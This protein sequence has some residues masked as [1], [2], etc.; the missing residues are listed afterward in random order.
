MP[1]QLTTT[2]AGSVSDGLSGN[3][4]PDIQGL[5]A[6]AVLMVVAFHAGLPVPGGFVGVD[7]F[8][9]ISGFV[10]TVMLKREWSQTGRIRLGQFYMRR[11]RR[12]TPALALMVA[13]TVPLSIL[14]LSPFGPQQNA[15][16]T[17]LGAMAFGAN[18]VIARTTG[19]Y[20]DAP[21]ETNPLLNTWSL[22]VEEQFYF[23]FPV[24]M[25][26][27]WTLARHRGLLR[28]SPVTL[29][30]SVAIV[31]FGL[32]LAASQRLAFRGSSIVL[33][34]YSPITR[35]WEFAVGALLALVLAKH[36][37]DASPPLRIGSS[38]I[39][40]CLVS[41]S[42][43]L[44]GDSTP[45]PGSWT[46]LPVVGTLLLLAG[47]HPESI[48]TRLLS[49]KPLVK[50]GDWSYSI[51]LWHWPFI[52]FAGVIWPGRTEFLLAAA[53]TS[54]LP[55]LASYYWV[56]Q[57]IRMSK[58]RSHTR[59]MGL[60]S[61]V[62]LPPVL[63]SAIALPIS[64]QWLAPGFQ[65]GTIGGVIHEG[66]VGHNEFHRFV[67]TTYYPCTPD[68]IRREALYW[69][70]FLRCQQSL[71]ETEVEVALV[72]DSHAE[73]LFLGLAE[74]APDTNIGYYILGALPVRSSGDGMARILDHVTYSPAIHTVVL[75]AFWAA[76]G[77]PEKEL[78][79]TIKRLQEA[80][81]TVFVTDDVPEFPF[82]PGQCRN[83]IALLIAGARC[84][85][86][87]WVNTE[88]Y[89][90]VITPLQ[91]VIRSV[92]GAHL[93]ETNK[94]FCG[95]NSC[96][97]AYGSRLLYRDPDHLN[98]NGTR[99]LADHLITDNQQLREA[100]DR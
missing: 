31:S 78:T 1:A 27:G 86:D 60:L 55:A 59:T 81:K 24:I 10:I 29:V 63:I 91:S 2:A 80:G 40:A 71:P 95:S 69:D 14:L 98:M 85:T 32:A 65:S 92:P 28:Y 26:L 99:F 64:D 100:L 56:E 77:V 38:L 61:A 89:L 9:V 67:Q 19:G 42:L 3:R 74:A 97:M 82:D 50:V 34:F 33:G 96:S 93:L 68:E 51:Y 12:L 21:A 23:A 6:V 66:D 46:L 36:A 57:P 73:H 20:F 44:I 52:V 72:G 11:F 48:V 54:L 30:S 25:A 8:F 13:V 7:V 70:D 17:A 83:R 45:S 22:S 58:Q 37:R 5:R 4:R 76:R 49:A 87:S 75:T 43:W 18:I 47:S 15:A 90:D 16:K 79:E 62:L 39:G 88:A 35:A 94:Y 84:E 41:A 53:L